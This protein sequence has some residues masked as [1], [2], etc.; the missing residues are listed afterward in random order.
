MAL[1]PVLVARAMSVMAGAMLSKVYT[2]AL[3]AALAGKVA[4]KLLP[5]VSVML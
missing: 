4:D 2:A 3:A 5:A 1:T